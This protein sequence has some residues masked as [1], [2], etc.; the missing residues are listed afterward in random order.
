MR[1][2]PDSDTALCGDSGAAA[3]RPRPSPAPCPHARSALPACLLPPGA[4]SAPS[5]AGAP[6]PP[7]RP[8]CR[9]M[10]AAASPA[11]W[12]RAPARR[13]R[14]NA[15]SAGSARHRDFGLISQTTCPSSQVPAFPFALAA[16]YAAPWPCLPRLCV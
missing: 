16:E 3:Q 12:G 6:P 10:A 9:P 13:N 14:A 1:Q 4:R 8:P 5:P 11:R 15:T 2:K 7:A